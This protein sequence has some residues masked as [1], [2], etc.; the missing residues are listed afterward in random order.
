MMHRRLQMLF[1]ALLLGCASA[2]IAQ[3]HPNL[4][5]GFAADKLYQFGEVDQV[6]LYNGNLSLTIP[7]GGSV[8]VSDRLSFSLTLIYNSKLWSSHPKRIVINGEGSTMPLYFPERRSNGGLGWSVSLG[9]LI[10]PSE[11]DINNDAAVFI[12]QGPDGSDRSFYPTLHVRPSQYAQEPSDP[13]VAYSRDNTYLRMRVSGANRLIESPDGTIRTFQSYADGIYTRWRLVQIQDRFGNHVD[14]DYSVANQWRVTDQYRPSD[15]GEFLLAVHDPQGEPRRRLHR[16][17]PARQQWPATAGFDRL[18]GKLV[19]RTRHAG[20]QR[21]IIGLRD[22]GGQ[23]RVGGRA[24]ERH[25][26]VVHPKRPDHIRH[27]GYEHHLHGLGVRPG[28]AERH[29][30]E[31]VRHERSNEDRERHRAPHGGGQRRRNDRAGRVGD[32]SRGPDGCRPVVRDVVRRLDA[33]EPHRLV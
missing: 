5:K 23:H 21:C 17:L 10:D 32:P 1:I 24:D 7:V 28:G 30:R 13:N 16:Y 12:Y 8:P 20:H 19:P 11:T 22:V 29:R 3:T 14:I 31:L 2:A 18:F 33:V 4:E 6:N 15:G 9:R 25:L 27:D 26:L